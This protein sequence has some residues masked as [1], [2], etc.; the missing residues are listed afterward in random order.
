ME[1]N[2][3]TFSFE[4]FPPKTSLG[5]EK[6]IKVAQELECKFFEVGTDVRNL[7]PYL[8]INGWTLTT[9]TYRREVNGK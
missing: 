1:K 4:F 8:K 6:L 3:K 2:S 5:L 9:S 7:D